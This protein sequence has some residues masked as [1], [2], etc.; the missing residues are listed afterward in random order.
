MERGGQR[1]M[2]REDIERLWSRQKILGG[3]K[4]ERD[5]KG[6]ASSKRESLGGS[7]RREGKHDTVLGLGGDPH[8]ISNVSGRGD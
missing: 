2:G 6:R 8:R 4:I 7:R 1:I 3:N 5:E